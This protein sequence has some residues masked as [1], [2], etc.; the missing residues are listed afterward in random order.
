MASE[1]QKILILE[2][3]GY[4]KVTLVVERCRYRAIR[5]ASGAQAISKARVICPNLPSEL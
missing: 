3:E 5:A 2:D 4:W 1:T